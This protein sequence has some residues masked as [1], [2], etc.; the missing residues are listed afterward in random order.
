MHHPEDLKAYAKKNKLHL[1]LM[2]SAHIL[3]LKL[4][5]AA[6]L[7]THPAFLLTIAFFLWPVRHLKAHTEALRA[8]AKLTNLP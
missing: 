1:K 6:F 4:T 5:I 7:L 8:N 2:I 3:N